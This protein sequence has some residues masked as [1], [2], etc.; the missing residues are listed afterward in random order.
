MLDIN[1]YLQLKKSTTNIQ[2]DNLAFGELALSDISNRIRLFVGK[3]D[4]TVQQIFDSDIQTED[5]IYDNLFQKHVSPQGDDNN[6]G[7][8][9]KPFQTIV[10]ALNTIEQGGIVVLES[11][12]YN[13]NIL[14]NNTFSQKSITGKNISNGI[15][16]RTY[17]NGIYDIAYNTEKICISNITF[18]NTSEDDDRGNDYILQI[19]TSSSNQNMIFNNISVSSSVNKTNIIKVRSNDTSGG[20]IDISNCD[21]NNKTIRLEDSILP[22][23]LYINNSKNLKL[24]AGTNWTVFVNNDSNNIVELSSNNNIFKPD[25]VLDIVST[26]PLINGIYISDADNISLG[27]SKGDVFV[28]IDSLIYV[29]EKYYCAKT[30]YYVISKNNSYIKQNGSYKE[31]VTYPIIL[32]EF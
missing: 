11:G 29:I 23:V 15:L 12:Y 2:P 9:N 7:Q 19:N 21:L 13:Q 27:V 17:L 10:K 32:N 31:L 30:I 6:N 3:N 5:Y 1:K 22:R 4:N 28:K 26:L 20:F 25:M 16:S 14:F 18:S 24:F 8:V